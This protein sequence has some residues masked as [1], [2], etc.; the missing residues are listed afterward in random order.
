MLII[1]LAT[2]PSIQH[3]HSVTWLFRPINARS[4]IGNDCCWSDGAIIHR[5]LSIDKI[6]VSQRQ[7]YHFEKSKICR[8]G[9]IIKFFKSSD[10]EDSSYFNFVDRVAFP[11]TWKEQLF[12]PYRFVIN[13]ESTQVC[14]LLHLWGETDWSL[15]LLKNLTKEM[16]RIY[17]SV[18]VHIV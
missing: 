13:L 9:C 2:W 10:Q 8:Y 11:I 4:V 17:W 12:H 1:Y 15:T 3:V 16:N 5:K 14:T 18:K 7:F 6:K